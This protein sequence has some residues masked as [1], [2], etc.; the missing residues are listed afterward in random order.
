MLQLDAHVL[1]IPTCNRRSQ[2]SICFCL[3][4]SDG[5][6]GGFSR[7]VAV[8]PKYV[9]RFFCTTIENDVVGRLNQHKKN[10]SPESGTSAC[11]STHTYLFMAFYYPGS[12]QVKVT[13]RMSFLIER[14]GLFC[15]SCCACRTVIRIEP[16]W[17]WTPSRMSST[18]EPLPG[19]RCKLT[20]T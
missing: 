16:G 13:Q 2:E 17:R 9:S 3:M 4:E 12:K 1:D 5:V 8:S 20:A 10:C 11:P 7:S 19:G 15:C 6:R 18:E 14:G